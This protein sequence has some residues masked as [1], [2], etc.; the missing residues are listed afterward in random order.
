MQWSLMCCYLNGLASCD[1]PY[2]G[3]P[4]SHY[5]R[6]N[7]STHPEEEK[8]KNVLWKLVVYVVYEVE[9]FNETS[10]GLPKV[11]SMKNH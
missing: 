6:L 2:V 11:S 10:G 3:T 8:K 7:A 5:W 4:G 1:P 9:L